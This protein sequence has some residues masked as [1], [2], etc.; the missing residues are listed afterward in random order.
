MIGEK[1]GKEV[2]IVKGEPHYVW[3]MDILN[4][5]YPKCY[6]CHYYKPHQ[7]PSLYWDGECLSVAHNTERGYLHRKG[8]NDYTSER[9]ACRWFFLPEDVPQNEANSEQTRMEL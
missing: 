3:P 1:T 2:F 5:N 7:K 9:N 8:G 6:Q 4:G